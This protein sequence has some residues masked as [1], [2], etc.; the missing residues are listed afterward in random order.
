MASMRRRRHPKR[1]R[2]PLPQ[3]GTA[4]HW[5][6]R[7]ARTIGYVRAVISR[8][9]VVLGRE[10]APTGRV[11]L[12]SYA[13]A[14][15]YTSLLR[16]QS[17][18]VRHGFSDL[19][20]WQ[21]RDLVKTPFYEEHRATLDERRGGGFWLW[22]A[23][24]ILRALEQ[25]DSGRRRGLRGFGSRVRR[26]HHPAPRAM[27][28]RRRSAALSWALRRLGGAW[29]ERQQSLDQARLLRP[30]GRRSAAS[31]WRGPS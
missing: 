13:T 4:V 15:W 8:R 18:A 12:T 31:V 16:L 14:E 9:A 27:S 24:I 30:H 21:R 6:K 2:E 7:M 11:V 10:V 1:V 17:S 5:R 26:R 22:K 25:A 3:F 19:Q 29:P 23:Y 20:T 28:A